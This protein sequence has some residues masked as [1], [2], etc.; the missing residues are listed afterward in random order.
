L[1]N[2]FEL[3]DDARTCQHHSYTYRNKL[4]ILKFIVIASTCNDHCG[5]KNLHTLTW[6]HFSNDDINYFQNFPF[7]NLSTRVWC[8][9]VCSLTNCVKCRLLFNIYSCKENWI[10]FIPIC[11]KLHPDI[12]LLKMYQNFKIF[13]TDGWRLTRAIKYVFY[14]I[15]ILENFSQKKFLLFGDGLI[16]CHFFCFVF[17]YFLLKN[18]ITHDLLF[19]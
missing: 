16:L 15:F 14:I 11:V 2:L 1:V 17:F 6:K 9:I 3:Y 13:E 7:C 8:H 5:E 18:I 12:G 10:T 19:M 4:W